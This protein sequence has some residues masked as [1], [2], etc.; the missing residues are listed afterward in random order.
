MASDKFL[1]AIPEIY[2]AL[3]VETI[4]DSKPKRGNDVEDDH[5][6]F[7]SW[8]DLWVTVEHGSKA[9]LEGLTGYA[10][11]GQLLA[12]MGPSGCGKS[13]LL[14]ALAGKH[15]AP[16]LSTQSHAKFWLMEKRK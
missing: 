3:E 14:D 12:I 7:L 2:S 16:S 10:C 15:T 8:E 13:T 11:P 5:G 1:Q 6:V 9:I 4:N